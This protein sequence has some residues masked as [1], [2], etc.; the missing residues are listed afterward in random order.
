[1]GRPGA[2]RES[3][4]PTREYQAQQER[5]EVSPARK[6]RAIRRFLGSGSSGLCKDSRTVMD[7]SS[8][9][10]G[11]RA[12]GS[13][14]GP[15]GKLRVLPM[16]TWMSRPRARAGHERLEAAVFSSKQA[17]EGVSEEVRDHGTAD[18]LESGSLTYCEE[19]GTKSRTLDETSMMDWNNDSGSVTVCRPWMLSF[20]E[21]YHRDSPL[22][23][24]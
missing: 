7:H 2:G 20:S 19:V 3:G 18:T 10:E 23:V 5:P 8:S 9:R 24:G 21:R 11:L 1:M 6:L 4:A 17:G 15:A 12:A 22:C 16:S 13:V 14:T